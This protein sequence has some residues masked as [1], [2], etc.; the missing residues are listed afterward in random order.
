M[1][2]NNAKAFGKAVRI[3]RKKQGI[4]QLQMAAVANTGL[5]FISDLEN[6]KPSIQLDKALRVA[7]LLGI[8]PEVEVP[9]DEK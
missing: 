1:K 9:G 7:W 6:G 3:Y 2:L 8:R 4:T 5:R